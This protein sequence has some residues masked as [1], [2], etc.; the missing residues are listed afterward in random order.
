MNVSPDEIKNM[1]I[2][3]HQPRYPNIDNRPNEDS[4]NALRD[5]CLNI[6]VPLHNHFGGFHVTYGFT[7]HKLLSQVKKLNPTHI[8]PNLDQHASYEVNTKGNIICDR[9]GAACDIFVTGF[10][11]R[12]Y[13]V[14]N[15]IADNSPFDRIYLYGNDRPIHISYGPEHNRFI[16]VMNTNKAGKRIPG[17]RGSNIEFD[18][19]IGEV[20]GP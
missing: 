9:G 4:L 14:A 6:L 11:N 15:W 20:N 17:K 18:S 7:S 5:L 1:V 13:D 8:A 10:E 19:I 3:W 2:N 16:Q 12:M